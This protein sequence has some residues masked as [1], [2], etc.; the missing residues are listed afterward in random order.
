[1]NTEQTI[2]IIFTYIPESKCS[3]TMSKYPRKITFGKFFNK[4]YFLILFQRKNFLMVNR[5]LHFTGAP[6]PEVL[7]KF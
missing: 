5:F 6:T 4:F 1:M 7:L 3:E 2:E